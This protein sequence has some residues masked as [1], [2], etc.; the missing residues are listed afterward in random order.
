MYKKDNQV[1]PIG[2]IHFI[3]PINPKIIQ[4]IGSPNVADHQSSVAVFHFWYL[5]LKSTSRYN[6]TK[7]R[8]ILIIN[9]LYSSIELTLSYLENNFYLSQ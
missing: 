9:T 1:I 4:E 3:S 7:W 2:V 8:M 6:N 5:V